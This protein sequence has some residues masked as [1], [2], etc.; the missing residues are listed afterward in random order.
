MVLGRLENKMQLSNVIP[1]FKYLWLTIKHKWFV[2]RAGLKVKAPIFRLIIHDWSKFLPIEFSNYAI[3]F[4]GDKSDPLKFS[5]AWNHHQKMNKHHWEY[6]VMVTGH[7]LGGFGDMEPL[8]MPEKYIRE[9]IA[10]WCGASKAYTG[11]W[12]WESEWVWFKENFPKLNLHFETKH[13]I[14]RI[15]KDELKLDV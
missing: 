12:P 14:L 4:F 7:N 9:M 10:D 1:T 15:I 13:L 2:F 3:Q 6:W 11:D 5:Y 8:P